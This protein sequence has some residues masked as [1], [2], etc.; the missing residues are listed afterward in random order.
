MRVSEYLHA[1]LLA[2]LASNSLAHNSLGGMNTLAITYS[3][4][5]H[6]ENAMHFQD[7]E[8]QTVVSE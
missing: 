3:G 4:F 6:H 8:N 5:G 2:V 1:S 7:P